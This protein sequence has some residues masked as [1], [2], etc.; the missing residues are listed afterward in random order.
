MSIFPEYIKFELCEDLIMTINDCI[1]P[2]KSNTLDASIYSLDLNQTIKSDRRVSQKSSFD[3]N[4]LKDIIQSSIYPLLYDKLT[5]SYPNAS[6][7]IA[8]ST[9][10][11]DYIKYDNGGYFEP[12]KD[13]VRINNPSQQQYT[14]L[15]GL[16][17]D[18]NNY[19]GCTVL[20]SKVTDSLESQSE[21]NILLSGPITDPLYIEVTAKYNLPK[22]HDLLKKILESNTSNIP[23]I[24]HRINCMNMGKALLFKSDIIH[25]GEEFYSW[26]KSKELFMCIINITGVE[27]KFIPINN[28]STNIDTQLDNNSYKINLWLNDNNSQIIMFDQFEMFMLKFTKLHRLIPFQIIVSSG[29]YLK[30]SFN[31][32]YLRFLNLYDE[33][34]LNK[35]NLNQDLLIN[36]NQTLDEIYT[37]TKTKLNKRGRETHMESEVLTSTSDNIKVLNLDG[38]YFDLSHISELRLDD[39][40]KIKNYFLN[41]SLTNNGII[42]HQEKIN[43]T[44]EESS[45]ND[46]GDEYDEIT[47][48]NCNI[49]IKFCFMKML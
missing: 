3:D 26:Y 37:K 1:Y 48:L 9:S 32:T 20:W 8:L 33:P 14:M 40:I 18:N 13:F 31:D 19:S 6:Y 30:K 47:Y 17:K 11:F 41:F 5:T 46:D 24:P 4:R 7:N 35:D 15:L 45:C 36:I 28:P 38:I 10:K 29:E 43:N 21:Y 34:V 39:I 25:S 2:Y 49:D 16:T 12:H 27:D 23:Y 42:T 44:W 22:N